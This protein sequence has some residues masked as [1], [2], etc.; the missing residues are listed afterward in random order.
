MNPVSHL[1][2]PAVP[3][4]QRDADLREAAIKLEASFLAEM[5][6]SAGVGEAR[7]SYGGGAGEDQFGSFLVRAQAEEMARAGGIGLAESLYQAL[8]EQENDR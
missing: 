4:P 1:S 5:L 2:S 8:K 7:S 6:K 3:P